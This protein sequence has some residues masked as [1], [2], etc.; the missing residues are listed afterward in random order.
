V[1]WLALLHAP[2]AGQPDLALDLLLA[3]L[4]SANTG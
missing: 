2:P 4:A 1:T 3:D